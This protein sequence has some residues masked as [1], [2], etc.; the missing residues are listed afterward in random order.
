MIKLKIPQ[1]TITEL[2][3]ELPPRLLAVCVSRERRIV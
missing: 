3:Q 1:L 2:A